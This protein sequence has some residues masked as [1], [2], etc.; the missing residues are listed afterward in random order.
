MTDGILQDHRALAAVAVAVLAVLVL[1]E[2]TLAWRLG[3]APRAGD[4]LSS[5]WCAILEQVWGAFAYVWI[6][7]LYAAI[8]SR[9]HLF[10]LPA[11]GWGFALGVVLV[12]VAF[13]VYHRFAHATGL[14]WAVHS[15]HHQPGDLHFAA[16]V[17]NS[18]FGG[19][20]QFPFMAPLA[21]LG[22]PPVCFLVGKAANPLYQL[23]VHTRT[24]PRIPV[25]DAVLNTPSNHRVH[26]GAEDRYR[27]R[28]FGGIF[29]VWDRLLGTYEPEGAE[30]TYGLDPP[31]RAADPLTANLAPWRDL[32]R[33]ARSRGWPSA[34]FGPPGAGSPSAPE[35]TPGTS[36]VAW[37]G[38]QTAVC[39][40][41][42]AHLLT[43]PSAPVAALEVVVLAGGAASVGAWLD[44]RW[45]ALRLDVV[46][47]AGTVALAAFVPY[48]S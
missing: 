28:N 2:G 17:R 25:L 16:A 6:L 33:C 48:L 19:L 4:V 42:L 47:V 46:R 11:N 3:H 20:V 24:V 30:P 29:V 5:L 31:F 22:L 7:A 38:V 43:V 26:H 21:L 32:A 14:G 34:L 23:W 40:G 1:A 39:L 41:V 45:W 12:D 36:A 15:V 8:Y 37:A 44:G 9:A 18:V 13:Y 35:R 10:D 27:D